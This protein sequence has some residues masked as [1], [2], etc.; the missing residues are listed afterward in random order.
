M[1][2]PEFPK[3]AKL[4]L[5][6][7][8]D[9]TR[10]TSKYPP[11]S[12]FNFSS[13]FSWDINGTTSVSML[14][15][16]LVV[17]LDDYITGEVTYSLLGSE[18]VDN[19]FD[20]MRALTTTLKL[21]PETTVAN[22][23][24]YDRFEITRDRD[25]YDYIF[26]IPEHA[27]LLGKQ[28]KGRR[29]KL[30]RLSRHYA[31]RITVEQINFKHTDTRDKLQAIFSQWAEGKNRTSE[32]V[33]NEYSAVQRAITY[34]NYLGLEG[35][36]LRIDGEYIGFSVVEV[37]SNGYGIYHFQKTLVD[38]QNLDAYLTNAQAMEL[39]EKGVSLIN[40]EQDLGIE[41]LR[42]LKTSYFPYDFLRKF[43]VKLS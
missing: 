5:E 11:Y 7:R 37:L 3:F 34:A 32:E 40:W 16:N 33:Q 29:N 1:N 31:E 26:S 28:Y 23:D 24:N 18:D 43:E 8:D 2:I 38:H 39:A 25:S 12:D 17:Q 27:S 6:H 9:I 19:C 30:H 4:T 22:L 35:L 21:V 41:G 10:I 13:L 42:H 36:F 20:D 14:K 15:G